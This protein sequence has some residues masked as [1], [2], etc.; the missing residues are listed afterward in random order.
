MILNPAA[1]LPSHPSMHM[2]GISHEFTANDCIHLV[3]KEQQLLKAMTDSNMKAVCGS[4][5][6]IG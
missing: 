6:T 1:L 2:R 3:V 5:K 4:S